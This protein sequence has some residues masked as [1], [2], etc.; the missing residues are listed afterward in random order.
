MTIPFIEPTS[1]GLLL[2]HRTESLPT[3]GVHLKDGSATPMRGKSLICR[4]RTLLLLGVSDP[5][6]H[7]ESRKE[8]PLSFIPRTGGL[9]LPVVRLFVRHYTSRPIYVV[10]CCD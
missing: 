2:G 5:K 4:Q 9:A 3:A 10:E 8:K 1:V 7:E 6:S